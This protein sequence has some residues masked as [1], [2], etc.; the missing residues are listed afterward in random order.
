MV[1]MAAT[2]AHKT[3][4]WLPQPPFALRR[5]PDERHAI[6]PVPLAC[7][8]QSTRLVVEVQLL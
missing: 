2:R 6:I 4:P 7:I 1:A 8:G 3:R 5:M